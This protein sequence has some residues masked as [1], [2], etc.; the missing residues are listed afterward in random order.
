MSEIYSRSP[1]NRTLRW[2]PGGD[3]RGSWEVNLGT[4]KMGWNQTLTS[5]SIRPKT[6]SLVNKGE[7]GGGLREEKARRQKV[8]QRSVLSRHSRVEKQSSRKLAL[9]SKDNKGRSVPDQK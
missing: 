3:D 8:V 5:T 7:W 1:T 6:G 2:A 4:K 9:S